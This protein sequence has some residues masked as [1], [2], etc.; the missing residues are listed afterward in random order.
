MEITP[1][2]GKEK[3]ITAEAFTVFLSR[4]DPVPEIAGE[5]YEELRRQLIKFFEWRGSYIADRLADE[6]LNRVMRKIDEG[7]EVEKNILAFSLGIARF[8]LL[9]AMRHPDNRRVELDEVS[10]FTAPAERRVEDDDLWVI[11][12]RECLRAFSRENRDL[13]IEYY[14]EDRRAKIDTRKMLAAKLDIS[15]NALFSRAKRIRDK[16][17]QCVTNCVEKKSKRA[18]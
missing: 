10:A 1:T 16:L 4:L 18:T 12:L 11:C 14:E 8:V 7:E 13:I 15:I 3:E 17:E 5:K 6:T 2:T 9:E